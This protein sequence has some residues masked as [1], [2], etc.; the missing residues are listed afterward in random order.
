MKMKGYDDEFLVA[1]L[2]H[3]VQNEMLAIAFMAKGEKP[4]KISLD[5]F[6]KEKDLAFCACSSLSVKPTLLRFLKEVCGSGTIRQFSGNK[7]EKE[8]MMKEQYRPWMRLEEMKI[9]EKGIPAHRPSTSCDMASE[10]RGYTEDCNWGIRY[11]SNQGL[12]KIVK[13]NTIE[14]S[15]ANQ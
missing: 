9:L 1:A 2:D 6:K 8:S 14:M 13:G 11:V 5:N 10:R 7:G 15:K 4:H 12:G 3:L